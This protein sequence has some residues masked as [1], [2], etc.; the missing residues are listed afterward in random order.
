MGSKRPILF[1]AASC[2]AVFWLDNVAIRPPSLRKADHRTL[3]EW[4]IEVFFEQ[5][6]L[7][8]QKEEYGPPVRLDP[9][10]EA[11][12]RISRFCW[13]V[14][15]GRELRGWFG[16]DPRGHTVGHLALEVEPGAWLLATGRCDLRHVTPWM[17]GVLPPALAQDL[18]LLELVRQLDA[19]E[20]GSL[21]TLSLARIE[22]A[23]AGLKESLL[24]YP[25]LPNHREQTDYVLGV[26]RGWGVDVDD[27]FV[28][29]DVED[30][31]RYDHE[32]GRLPGS[33][34]RA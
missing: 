32:R 13:G 5:R 2:A 24:S 22:D 27:P 20:A 12:A 18:A 34:A 6:L 17:R 10:A 16:T 26:L 14:F 8:E 9:F 4:L 31:F 28:R 11:R 19:W 23:V 15:S 29:M 1:F 21:A 30:G 25:N 7:S 33:D 3:L